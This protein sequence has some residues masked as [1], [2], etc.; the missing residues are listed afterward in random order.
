MSLSATNIIDSQRAGLDPRPAGSANFRNDRADASG[1]SLSFLSTLHCPYCGSGLELVSPPAR[2][3]E[4]Q[5]AGV[6]QYGILRCGCSQYP[7][8]GGVPIIQHVEG[9]Q[10]VVALI[11]TGDHQRALLQAMNLFR[12]KWAQRTRWHQVKYHLNCRRLVSRPDLLFQD[13]VDLARRPKVFSDYLFHRY[14]NPSFLGAIGPLLLLDCFKDRAV[15][16]QPIRVM[17]LACGAGH[18]SFLMRLLHPG[19]SVVS[20]DHDFVSLYLAKRF[21]APEA[22]HLCLDAEVASP[23]ADDYFDAAFCLD[24]FHYFHSKMAIVAELKRVLKPEALWLFPHLHNALQHNITAGTPLSPER[25]LACF[26]SLDPRLFDETTILQGLSQRHTLDLR[27]Q[28]TP[29]ELEKSPNLTLIAGA[30]NFWREH[31]LFPSAFCRHQ[32]RLAL[33][34]IYAWEMRQDRLEGTLTWPNEV[35]R[36]ECHGVEAVLP[37]TCR[38]NRR[39]LQDLLKGDSSSSNARLE[40]LVAQFVLVPL[41]PNYSRDNEVA[42]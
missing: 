1:V 11:E 35:M 7:V 27:A 12:V 8:V 29:G 23:F 25:Y 41:P 31:R 18:S 10:Q 16:N 40:E 39:E 4:A 22:T 9:L 2:Q 34:P 37:A 26:D 28:L 30:Q 19:L 42:V 6:V 3:S 13:A 33:N 21:L 20:V 17:D 14:A 15:S 32:S 24:A 5:D 38:L 36:D